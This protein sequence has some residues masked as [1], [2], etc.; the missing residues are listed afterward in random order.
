IG[1]QLWS[2][3]YDRQLAGV[4]DVQDEITEAVVAAIEPQIYAA[5]NFRARRKA[6]ENLDAWGLVM[7]ALSHYWSVTAKTISRL[8]NCLS[9]QLPSIPTMLRHL[10]FL[11][12]VTPSARIWVGRMC[13]PLSRSPNARDWR[14]SRPTAKIL[15]HILGLPRL[16]CTCAASRT[17]LPSS[18]WLCASIRTSPSRK[19]ITGWAWHT[20]GG[21][22]KAPTRPVM[23]C[24]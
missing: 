24:V 20:V 11:P 4:F 9:R 6:P 14:L 16:A 18:K 22:R 3:R 19:A 7:R 23:R 12:S 15:G 17:R 2:E 13:Q 10:P 21:G 1:N 5:E 8:R